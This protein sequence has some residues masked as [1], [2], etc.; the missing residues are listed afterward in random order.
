MNTMNDQ[1]FFDLAMKAAAQQATAAEHAELDSLLAAEPERKAE[2]ERLRSEVK[3]AQEVLPLINATEA[4]AGELPG[5][6]RGRLQTKVRQTYGAPK[7][8][9]KNAT[10]EAFWNWRWLLGLAATGIVLVLVLVGLAAAVVIALMAIPLLSPAS[11]L[12]VRVA[13]LDLAGTSRGADTNEVAL[14]QQTWPMATM[15]NFTKTTE[16]EAWEK[17]TQAQT[18]GTFAKIIY[19]RS[20]GEV[21]VAGSANGRSFERVFPAGS[22]LKES[23]DAARVFVL[24]QSK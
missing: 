14:L 24:E 13:M 17:T 23:L 4:T 1:R 12:V 9:A 20:A 3:L 19:D 2:M 15:T 6:A 18:K 11:K 7:E 16:L 10:T 8:T 22:N 21:R 5:Y